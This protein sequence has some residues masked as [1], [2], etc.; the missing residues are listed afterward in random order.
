MLNLKGLVV[1]KEEP[2]IEW[3]KLSKSKAGVVTAADIK[4][5]AGCEILNKDLYITEIDKDGLNLNIDIR[6]EKATGYVSVSDLKKIEDDVNVLVIDA[7]FSPVLNVRYEI[8]DT[9]Y[10]DNTNLDSLEMEVLTN[11]IISPEDALKFS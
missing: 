7:N 6:I 4:A 9:R 11:G 10:G 5:P 3:L 8:T 1:R 2:G